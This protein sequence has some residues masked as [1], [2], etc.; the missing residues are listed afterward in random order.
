MS[1]VFRIAVLLVLVA[2]AAWAQGWRG[3]GRVGGK[4]TDEARKPIE[5]VVVKLTL[6]SE[7]GVVEVKTNSKGDWS[8]GGIARGEWQVDFTKAKFEARHISVSVSEMSRIPPIE[9]TLKT[10]E[11]PNEI[12]AVE[13]KRAGEML[14]QKKYAEARSVYEAL[15]AR[16][17]QAYRIEQSVARTYYLEGQ[18][19]RAIER[20]KSVLAKD[21][22]AVEL[23]LLLGSLLLE[24]G[25]ADEG[26]QVLSSVDESKITEAAIYVN[27]GIAMMNKGQG[28]EAFAYFDKAITRFPQDPDAYYYRGITLLQLSGAQGEESQKSDRLQKAKVDLTKFIAMAPNAPE[29]D[30]AKKILEQLK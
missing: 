17:P 6:P 23:K 7:N 16:Y 22:E 21:P 3:Q 10:A 14:T 20:L 13:M 9:T 18:P 24:Q 27:F 5:G 28:A 15:L 30:N 4:V 26:K 11:D 29:A 1:R 12:I 25:R 2:T 8:V 19:D